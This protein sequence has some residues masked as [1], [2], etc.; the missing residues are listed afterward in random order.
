LWNM[1]Q[2]ETREALEDATSQLAE[3]GAVLREVTLPDAFA[4][5]EEVRILINCYE[6]SRHMTNE[7]RDHRNHLSD[8][9]QEVM[10]TGLD[11]PYEDY[12]AAMRL[13]EGC[14][15]Q[16]EALFDDLDI[17]LAPCV[18]GEAPEGL[19]NGGSPRFAGLWTA[20]QLPTL[21][22]PTYIGPN[23]MPVGVQL[24]GRYRGDDRLLSAAKWVLE[25]LEITS[26]G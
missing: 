23:R 3:A 9:F 25:K 24:V 18:D 19:E 10:K 12:V 15:R 13:T 6:R 16:S 14:R 2:T 7:W 20:I 26:V 11:A 21:S 1:A 22:L 8:R 5:L 4:R 17:L